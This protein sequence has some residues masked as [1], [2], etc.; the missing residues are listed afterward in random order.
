[1]KR[2]EFP[3]A[4]LDDEHDLYHIAYRREILKIQFLRPAFEDLFRQRGDHPLDPPGIEHATGTFQAIADSFPA[5][6][7]Q[8]P[9]HTGVLVPVINGKERLLPGHYLHHSR[10]YLGFWRETMGR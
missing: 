9:D 4:Y 1:M 3:P 7:E 2:W 5:V 6:R 8:R 10:M